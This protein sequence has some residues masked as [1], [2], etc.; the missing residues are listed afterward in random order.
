MDIQYLKFTGQVLVNCTT[1]YFL[2]VFYI[3]C[4]LLPLDL[5]K[6]VAE[7]IYSLLWPDS[8][9]MCEN[10]VWALQK[11]ALTVFQISFKA[12]A[13]ELLV[14]NMCSTVLVSNVKVCLSCRGVT[15]FPPNKVKHPHLYTYGGDSYKVSLY[16]SVCMK[17]NRVY[18][19]NTYT[20]PVGNS[21]QEHCTG[22][23]WTSC[24]QLANSVTISFL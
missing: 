11:A 12:E 17:C 1:F 24:L 7:H 4:I 5:P 9:I 2:L 15:Q 21:K 18:S 16:P 23:F 10:G 14:S 3:L 22:N 13:K 20:V 19:L 6:E 8:N